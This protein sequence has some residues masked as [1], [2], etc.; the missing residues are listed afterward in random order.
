M[1]TV[2]ERTRG[3]RVAPDSPAGVMVELRRGDQLVGIGQG[4]DGQI[5]DTHAITSVESRGLV[6]RIRCVVRLQ[7]IPDGQNEP[8]VYQIES[9]PTA[10]WLRESRRRRT[11]IR[12]RRQ[13]RARP[14]L[15]DEQEQD[16]H[17]KTGWR[18]GY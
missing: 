13:L 9:D 11:T 5:V 4:R 6:E 14:D 12:W 3:R 18:G 17:W 15:T 16:A 7:V 2:A 8:Q 10:R 1:Q